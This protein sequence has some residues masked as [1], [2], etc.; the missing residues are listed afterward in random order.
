MAED[1]EKFNKT[2]QDVENLEFMM[3]NI[4]NSISAYGP[5]YLAIKKVNTDISNELGKFYYRYP[6]F[7]EIGQAVKDA[8]EF[9]NKRIETLVRLTKFLMSRTRS[10]RLLSHSSKDGS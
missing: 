2:K 1:A 4:Q 9:H 7:L 10:S 6:E 5:L 8:F 3:K